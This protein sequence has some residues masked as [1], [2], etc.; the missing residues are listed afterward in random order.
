MEEGGPSDE[1][2][3]DGG[4]SNGDISDGTLPDGC[5]P[6]LN[7]SEGEEEGMSGEEVFSRVLQGGVLPT[8]AAVGFIGSYP[9]TQAYF[10]KTRAHFDDVFENCWIFFLGGGAGG[11]NYLLFTFL[12]L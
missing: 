12:N 7:I 8:L 10:P 4:L 2:L 11:N 9:V 1:D 3:S 5:F 6:N